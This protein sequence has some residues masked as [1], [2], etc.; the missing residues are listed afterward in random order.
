MESLQKAAL[1]ILLTTNLFSSLATATVY[2]CKDQDGNTVYTDNPNS[3]PNCINPSPKEMKPLPGFNQEQLRSQ[4]KARPN[5]DKPVEKLPEYNSVNII[6]PTNGETINRC[7]GV[8]DIS[9]EIQPDLFSGDTADLYI[10]GAKH[11][12]AN[13]GGSITIDNL[14]RGNHS[15]SVKI[16]RNNTVVKSS[17][18][19][20]FTFLRNCA[21]RP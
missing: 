19:I 11:S 15:V 2:T 5:T 12:S 21:R 1:L 4:L 14:N 10:D 9:F 7:G 18:N 17:D 6:S 3:N 16:I 13:S 20:N 8:M